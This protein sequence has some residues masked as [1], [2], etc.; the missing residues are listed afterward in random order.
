MRNLSLFLEKISRALNKDRYIK[1][2]VLGSIKEVSGIKLEDTNI[3]LKEGI[4][5]INTTPGRKNEIVLKEREIISNL[6][7][8]HNINI[9]KV[10]YR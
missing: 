10:L 8:S 4:L 2:S 1:E 7:N 5:Q 3:S 9:V 6:K